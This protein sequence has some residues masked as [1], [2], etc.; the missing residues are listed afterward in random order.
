MLLLLAAIV[1]GTSGFGA[2]ALSQDTHW[3]TVRRWPASRPPRWLRTA[4]WAL[5][6]I[7]AVP[8]LLR[9]GMAFGLLLWIGALS[10]SAV[11]IVAF[12]TWRAKRSG[13][14]A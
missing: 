7:S 4:G 14:Q 11:C 9:D 1:I 13:R 2:L 6:G 10:M 8:L 3:K 5:V 12:T